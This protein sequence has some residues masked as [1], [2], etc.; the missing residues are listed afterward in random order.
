MEN[1]E[2]SMIWGD[3]SHL[4]HGKNKLSYPVPPAAKKHDTKLAFGS[5]EAAYIAFVNAASTHS[6][7]YMKAASFEWD[8]EQGRIL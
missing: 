7:S 6:S 2:E 8:S 4:F 5:W 3:I 1:F